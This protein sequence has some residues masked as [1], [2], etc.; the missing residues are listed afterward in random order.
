MADTQ[1]CRVS[2]GNNRRNCMEQGTIDDPQR[3]HRVCAAHQPHPVR[4]MLLDK[5]LSMELQTSIGG[6]TYVISMGALEPCTVYDQPIATDQCK[7]I[8]YDPDPAHR[9]RTVHFHEHC[10]PIYERERAVMRARRDL[11]G[12]GTGRRGGVY[13]HHHEHLPLMY[14]VSSATA[15]QGYLLRHA[16]KARPAR[17]RTPVL[18][19]Y[20]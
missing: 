3:G 17:Q 7:A 1:F 12:S 6:N 19:H 15:G 8:Y 13:D 2:P 10:T 14:A 4:K 5:T 9:S 16:M 11:P 20:Y 18:T